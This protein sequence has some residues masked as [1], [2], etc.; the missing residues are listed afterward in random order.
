MSADS[1]S[2]AKPSDPSLRERLGAVP[3]VDLRPAIA[4]EESPPEPLPAPA[5]EAAPAGDAPVDDAPA[6]AEPVPAPVVDGQQRGG[7]L[8]PFLAG[9]LAGAGG[10]YAVLWLLA[11][12]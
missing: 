4:P 12:I 9:A 3:V 7:W 11:L 1:G 5:A 10:F 8:V 2:A 6:P